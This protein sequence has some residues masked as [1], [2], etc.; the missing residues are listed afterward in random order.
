MKKYTIALMLYKFDMFPLGMRCVGGAAE[1]KFLPDAF[2]AS[3]TSGG[4]R[5][6]CRIHSMAFSARI[7]MGKLLLFS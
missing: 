7:N 2:R 3:G 6:L 1:L 4:A 5:V